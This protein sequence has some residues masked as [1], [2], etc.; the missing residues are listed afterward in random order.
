MD[1]TLPT[2]TVCSP[3]DLGHPGVGNVRTTQRTT[4]SVLA[5]RAPVLRGRTGDRLHTLEEERRERRYAVN[6]SESKQI[7]ILPWVPEMSMDSLMLGSIYSHVKK[8]LR[9][10]PS[11]YKTIK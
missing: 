10:T 6:A 3:L 1:H 9:I 2:N 5:L 11:K 4:Q 8:P 7:D